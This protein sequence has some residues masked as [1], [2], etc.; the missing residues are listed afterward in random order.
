MHERDWEGPHG[1]IGQFVREESRRTLNAYAAQPSLVSEQANQEMDTARGGYAHRQ[2][3]ELIQ[4]SA[5]QI[6]SEQGHGNGRILIRLSPTHL[7]CA[8]DGA[9][10]TRGGA[11]ALLFSHLSPKRDTVEIGRFG[12]G[13][14]AVLRISD[15][16]TVFSRSGSIQFDRSRAD[17]RISKVSPD[18]PNTPVLRVADPI[19]AVAES[20]QDPTLRSLMDWAVNIVRMPLLPGCEEDLDTQLSDFRA[21]FLL[22]AQHVQK[23]HFER[24][25]KDRDVDRRYLTLTS[26]GDTHKLSDNEDESIWKVFEREHH[27]SE[28]AKDDHR[29][30]DDGSTVRIVW[31]APQ[32]GTDPPQ[33]FWAYFPTQTSSLVDGILNAPWKTNEDRQ[34]LLPG[35]YN[36]ELITATAGLVANS[37]RALFAPESPG[38]HLGYLPRRE[39][40]GDNPYANGLRRHI[41]ALLQER[42]VIPNQLGDLQSISQLKV[43]PR[44]V[45]IGQQVDMEL[46]DLWASYPHRPLDWVHHDALAGRRLTAIGRI[47][48]GGATQRGALERASVTDWVLA[49]FKGGIAQGDPVGASTA[50]IKVAAALE[51][52]NSVPVHRRIRDNAELYGDIVFTQAGQWA[53]AVR[54]AVFLAS[55]SSDDPSVTVHQ[56]LM[57][58]PE[59]VEALETLGIQSP[60]AESAFR[61]VA[62]HMIAN[63][64]VVR[65]AT[66]WEEFWRLSR[67]VDQLH[68][69]NAVRTIE[70]WRSRIMARAA[71]GNWHPISD[72]LL[73]GSIVSADAA[74]DAPFT[75][76]MVF[77]EQDRTRLEA[78][79]VIERP[80]PGNWDLVDQF[81]INGPLQDYAYSCIDEYYNRDDLP[82]RNPQG[83]YFPYSEQ[84]VS[85]PLGIV[86]RLS[87]PSRARCTQALLALESTYTNWTMWHQ[88]SAGNYPKMEVE[89][90]VIYL[91][92]RFGIVRTDSGLHPL[93]DG[94]GERPKNHE[95]RRWLLDRPHADLIR[96][97]FD[98]PN[99][100][101]NL[102]TRGEDEPLPLVDAWPGLSEHLQTEQH[103]LDFVRCDALVADDGAIAFE[104][105][106]I[107]MPL[108]GL[109]QS[110]VL[111]RQDDDQSELELLIRE[112]GLELNQRQFQSVLQRLTSKEVNN[113]RAEVRNQPN[114]ALRLSKAVGGSME[115]L[116][117]L[118]SSLVDILHD[119]GVVFEG[120]RIAEAAIATYHTAVLR[121]YRDLLQHLDPPRQ[122]AGRRRT[123]EFVRSLG[124]PDEWAGR[125]TVKREQ[126][127]DVVGPRSLPD[128]HPYQ[129][130][131]ADN[132]R[133][134]VRGQSASGE[135]RGLLSLPTG[136]GK[137]RVAV[138]AIIEAIRDDGF[139][140]T[141]LWVADRDE[142]CEQ[143]VEA[144][145]QAWMSFGPEA[146][147]LRISRLW[148]N[149]P[150]PEER[151][152][153]THV[154]VATI[155]TLTARIKRVNGLPYY[156]EDVGL[157]VIDEAHGSIAPTYTS[158][159]AE[160]GLTFRRTVDEIAL[161]GLTATPY[162]GTNEEE[163]R[164][165]VQRYGAHRLDSG[166]FRNDDPQDV[167]RELQR[168]KVLSAVD[169]EVIE[170]TRISLD[171]S[172]L[173]QATDLPWLP[174][175]AERRIANNTART[176]RIIAAYET[177]V[178][179]VDPECPTLI[180]A[181]SV[182]HANTLAAMLHLRGVPARAISGDTDPHVRRNAVNE[183]RSG[184]LKVL[185]NYAVFREGFDAPQTRALIV[186]RPVYSPNLYFQMIGRGLRGKLNGGSERCLI[187][188]VHDNIVNYDRQL[189]YT[190][191][192][193]LWS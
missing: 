60:S 48:D 43:A 37:L 1:T 82:S 162:R 65:T 160:L 163:T 41:Y 182:E 121:E 141:V 12:V 185:V 175:S 70:G 137:T 10:L 153:A 157:L 134:L 62:E 25:Y 190:E 126:Y 28:E 173:Q 20:K 142:L 96:E 57:G 146:S 174:G 151:A 189:A 125:P 152:G 58:N 113:R 100:I 105:C 103:S 145:Q 191:L 24:V 136:S 88:T 183:F 87:P 29:A 119:E 83:Q 143:A 51:N 92:R 14:K 31:A 158:L 117:R 13:F 18:A 90:P 161:L 164:R 94:L 159:L 116:T 149:Q 110:I 35:R 16:P 4:N 109:M 124:F 64:D 115:L 21:E 73:P 61:R 147:S 75:V 50:T 8:D 133:R 56:L 68:F 79:D 19:D 170:G 45:H 80:R 3:I 9:P 17:S 84:P 144:W 77:H 95:V 89:S 36:D 127:V 166:A 98:L 7:Y 34:S 188:D 72:L 138:Q 106:V 71:D 169:H 91:L 69:L 181:T 38:R 154:I 5:D 139:S 67:K 74:D 112:L 15:Q 27:L 81:K 178:R 148:R 33:Q 135:N 193:D 49:L 140:S 108:H 120:E 40:A 59:V 76:D 179:D 156:L 26:A 55:G 128:L 186:A 6:A 102:S 52:R 99:Q 129:R 187:L 85:G 130:H 63:I 101:G 114:D 46:L 118:P 104:Q 23:L 107:Q 150:Q 155:Q 97:A 123:L 30:L 165:L 54:D 122:W 42:A 176:R 132:V 168:M 11:K 131:A 171:H 192:D 66:E 32:A 22:F 44:E 111:V 180:F 47:T 39:E 172:E 93:A 177:M 184:R 167:I 78:L 53:P 2:I 86:H